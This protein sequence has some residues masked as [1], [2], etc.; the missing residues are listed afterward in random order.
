MHRGTAT[1]GNLLLGMAAARWGTPWA[2][3]WGAGVTLFAGL[4]FVLVTTRSPP[5]A[6]LRGG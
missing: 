3:G 6:S 4:P 5:P 1:F 2:I